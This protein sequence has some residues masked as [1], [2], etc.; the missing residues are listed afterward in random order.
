MLALRVGIMLY[1]SST[2]HPIE[3]HP[4][5][6]GQICSG[7]GICMTDES[8]EASRCFCNTGFKGEDCSKDVG[9]SMTDYVLIVDIAMVV[10]ILLTMYVEVKK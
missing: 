5:S 1:T 4:N 8:I 9:L 10:V 7:H 2:P 6:K 3:C